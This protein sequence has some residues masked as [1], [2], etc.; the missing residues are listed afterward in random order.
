MTIVLTGGGSGGHI[1]PILAIADELKDRNPSPQLI[2]IGKRGD[3]L[4]DIPASHPSID[5]SYSIRAGKFR[6]YHGQWWRHIL[7]IPL[8]VRNLRDGFW[9]VVG[10]WQSF[11]LLR[12]LKPNV[13]FIK[14]GF[15]GVPVGLVAGWLKI[16]YVTHDSDTLPGLANRLIAKRASAHAVGGPKQLYKYPSH[17]TFEVGVP[18]SEQY[19]PVS[20]QLQSEYRKGLGIKSDV[21]VICVTGG[22]LGAKRLN[23]AVSAIVPE[24]LVHYPS[25][26]V[27]HISG[28]DHEEELSRRYENTLDKKQYA[29]VKVKGFV[30]DLYRYTAA[31]DVVVSRAGATQLAELAIQKKPAIVVPNPI[32]T[33]G[34]Q[35]KNA[36]QLEKAGAI[37]SISEESLANSPNEIYDA[38]RDLLDHQEKRSELAKRL[39]KTAKPKAA[40]QLAD[41]IL[42][43]A[44]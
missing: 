36:K 27:L 6:R 15:V 41:L 38:L 14:G 37:V 44:K 3:K 39:G 33:A 23:D 35:L 22:G 29:Q 26:V 13:I 4:G 42:K 30:N 8:I 21:K 11:W 28:R 40:M 7:D 1:T 18:L 20:Y 12:R 32:L 19:T 2:Y 9:V 43:V 34:H 25:L 10:I 31:A 16:P 17:K 5:Q 24:L